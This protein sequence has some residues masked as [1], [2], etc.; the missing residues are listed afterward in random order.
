MSSRLKMKPPVA[1]KRDVTSKKL[2]IVSSKSALLPSRVVAAGS[3]DPKLKPPIIAPRT[4]LVPPVPN[5]KS[6]TF[7]RIQT[8]SDSVKRPSGMSPQFSTLLCLHADF[9][10][11]RPY[12]INDSSHF[13]KTSWDIKWTCLTSDMITHYCVFLLAIRKNTL[14]YC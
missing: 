2:T 1:G 7:E 10:S 11:T 12:W 8:K 4:R 6:S 3:R 14:I 5:K 13:A 9:S